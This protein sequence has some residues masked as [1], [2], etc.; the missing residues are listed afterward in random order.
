MD[1]KVTW[2]PT[3]PKIDHVWWSPRC[4]KRTQMFVSRKMKVAVSK[5]NFYL[6]IVNFDIN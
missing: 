3:C 2:N 6:K 1:E 5:L 4:G